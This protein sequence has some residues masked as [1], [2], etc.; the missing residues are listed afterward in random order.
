MT[1]QKSKTVTKTATA[2]KAETSGKP[3][4]EKLA[5]SFE[6]SKLSARKAAGKTQVR[7]TRSKIRA[8]KAQTTKKKET[9]RWKEKS[10]GHAPHSAR[11]SP[12]KGPMQAVSS[13]TTFGPKYNKNRQWVIIDAAGHTVGRL[14]SEIASLLRGKHKPS[15]TPNNDAG[16]FVVVIN[17]EKVRFTSTKDETKQYFNHSGWI[18]GLKVTTPAR[19]RRTYPTRILEKAVKGMVPRNPLGR[20]QMRKLK[21]YAGTEHPHTAQKPIVWSLRS[22]AQAAE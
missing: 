4:S 16:D 11:I 6:K 7:M 8:N 13:R 17:C 21:L 15:F 18:G 3:K 5:K 9:S 2:S 22:Q 12:V 20:D 1:G 10:L 14:A 19:L